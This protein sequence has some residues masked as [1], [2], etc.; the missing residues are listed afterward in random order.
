M[1]C[2]RVTGLTRIFVVDS[3][4]IVFDSL[5][6]LERPRGKDESSDIREVKTCTLCMSVAFG[7]PVIGDADPPRPAMDRHSW[8][9]GC[10]LES[11]LA[12][13]WGGRIGR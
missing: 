1:C 9:A 12:F 7:S 2:A 3:G 6:Q 13:V 11:M 4:K 8:P 10:C 5:L